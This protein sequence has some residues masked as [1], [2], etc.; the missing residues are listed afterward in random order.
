MFIIELLAFGEFSQC[1]DM[2]HADNAAATRMP[3][4]SIVRK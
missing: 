1:E 3:E 2:H 4:L